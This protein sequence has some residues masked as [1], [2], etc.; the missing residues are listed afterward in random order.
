M[1]SFVILTGV[2]EAWLSLGGSERMES[3]VL[4]EISGAGAC[5]ANPPYRIS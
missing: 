2:P 5:P 4:G 1:A 3:S